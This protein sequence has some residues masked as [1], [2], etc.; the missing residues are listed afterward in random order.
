MTMSDQSDNVNHPSHYKHPSGVESIDI[1]RQLPFDLGNAVKYVWRAGVKDPQKTIED[2]RKAIWYLKDFHAYHVTQ[3]VPFIPPR[4]VSR[5][6]FRV[7]DEQTG[8]LA[9]FL[10]ALFR[11]TCDDALAGD[12]TVS[13]IE[14][15]ILFLQG[16]IDAEYGSR[17]FG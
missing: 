17:M 8:T 16:A 10:R 1:C 14:T 4:E 7:Q 2:Y 6:A 3:S 11:L 15:A 9:G 12:I 13:S 5:L